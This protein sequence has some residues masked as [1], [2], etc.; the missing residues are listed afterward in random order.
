VRRPLLFLVTEDRQ[1]AIDGCFPGYWSLGR[2][3]RF[4]GRGARLA[5]RRNCQERRGHDKLNLVRSC[6]IAPESGRFDPFRPAGTAKL[7][8]NTYKP[9]R[10]P[11]PRQERAVSPPTCHPSNP[12]DPLPHRRRRRLGGRIALRAVRTLAEPPP[13]ANAGYK[14][15]WTMVGQVNGT[16]GTQFRVWLLEFLRPGWRCRK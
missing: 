6:R 15:T 8:S 11:N 3:K 1:A 10:A 14:L 7:R 4:K 2:P 16:P 13:G 5:A 9:G 12:S